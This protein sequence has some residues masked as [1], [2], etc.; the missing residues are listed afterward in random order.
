MKDQK[1]NRARALGVLGKIPFNGML[2]IEI[3]RL[4]DD[5]VTLR[6]KVRQELLNSHGA[7]HGGVAA[8]LADVAVGVAIH[9]H[10]AGTRPISTVEL[11]VNY[12]RPVKEGTLF[13]RAR[14]LRIGSTLCVGRVDLTDSEAKAVGTAIVTYMF[15]DARVA[16][17]ERRPGGGNSEGC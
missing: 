1:Q 13:A 12:F 9:R 2:G 6:C 16:H 5:G 10:S 4:H 7:L 11:K 17:R 3:S 14:L 15:L 8:S